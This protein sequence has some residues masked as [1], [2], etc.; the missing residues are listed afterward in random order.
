[1]NNCTKNGEEINF[2]TLKQI[3]NKINTLNCKTLV[4]SG[5]EP[6]EH[7]EFI[8]VF[9]YINHKL[10]NKVC[11]VITSNGM[12][13]ENNIHLYNSIMNINNNIMFQITNDKRFYPTSL[14]M[15][16]YLYKKPNVIVCDNV[17]RIYPLGRAKL[18]NLPYQANAS[19]CFNLRLITAQL[20]LKYKHLTLKDI[21]ETLEQNYKF[22]SLGYDYQGNIRLGESNLCKVIGNIDNDDNTII[23]NILFDECKT[24]EFINKKVDKMYTDIIKLAKLNYK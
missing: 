16:S 6:T 15:N 12:N 8:N 4:I 1:M 13:L 21:N 9:K 5:G 17:E 22:C 14:N 19:K 3:C 18:N 10:K 2:N 23:K 20:S 7:S 24:C 11:Y